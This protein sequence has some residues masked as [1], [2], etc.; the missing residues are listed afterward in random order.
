MPKK[1]LSMRSDKQALKCHREAL[2][3]ALSAL[4]LSAVGKTVDKH[5]MLGA[6]GPAARAAVD[7]YLGCA[8][9]GT[10]ELTSIVSRVAELAPTAVRVK[11]LL[12]SVEVARHA[13]SFATLAAKGSAVDVLYDL[14]CGHGMVG[15]LLAYRFPRKSR[16]LINSSLSYLPEGMKKEVQGRWGRVWRISCT[17]V[18]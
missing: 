18:L 5:T 3:A 9:R 4:P 14:A 7:A 16:L 1:K 11:E 10:P 2:N 12:E 17:R 15:V 13:A 8:F 6:L